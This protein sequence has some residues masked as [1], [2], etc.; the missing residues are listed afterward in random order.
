MAMSRTMKRPTPCC[1]IPFSQ[2]ILI[3]M[4]YRSLGLPEVPLTECCVRLQLSKMRSNL[5]M[6]TGRFSAMP[7]RTPALAGPVGCEERRNACKWSKC[8]RDRAIPRRPC[9]SSPPNE[10]PNEGRWGWVSQQTISPSL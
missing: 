4:K 2:I 5:L 10:I 3:I 6:P 1:L 9:R 8:R 7:R